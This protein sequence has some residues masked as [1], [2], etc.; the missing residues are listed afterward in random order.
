MKWLKFFIKRKA[1]KD[2]QQ[3]VLFPS[4]SHA[5]SKVL[6]I[7]VYQ[8]L[9][10][11]EPDRRR[12]LQRAAKVVGLT[13][14]AMGREIAQ[15]L[16]LP[17]ITSPD[18]S[19]IANLPARYSLA[20]FRRRGSIPLIEGGR[21]IGAACVD[22]ALLEGCLD[23]HPRPKFIL[24]TW[25]ALVQALVAVNDLKGKNEEVHELGLK[26]LQCILEEAL[27]YSARE[28]IISG[29]EGSL[30][31]R[32][33]VEGDL[34]A[35]GVVHAAATAPLQAL[36]RGNIG[37]G[38]RLPTLDAVEFS[39]QIDRGN[40]FTLKISSGASNVISL[41]TSIPAPEPVEAETIA[42]VD[43]D[44]SLLL[45]LKRFLEKEGFRVV[46][47]TSPLDVL[48]ALVSKRERPIVLLSDMHMPQMKGDELLKRI[49]EDA[50]ICSTPVI[51]LTS[52][53][54]PATHIRVLRAGADAYVTKNSHP[55][56][57]LAHIGRVKERASL[58]GVG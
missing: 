14:E 51:L 18:P 19:S 50:S 41:P 54:D 39:V 13:E 28:I 1:T 12:L 5:L 25:D 20:E 26:A 23:P 35:E 56:I 53:E 45:V 48:D 43:D 4:A 29:E 52:D 44:P 32:F 11:N 15:L 46:S 27:T 22:P 10:R 16:G 36:L 30:Q 49:R 34:M 58:L 42:I 38:L 7:P 3:G 8:D 57:I 17:F 37:D 33:P 24:S 9:L 40:G 21:V 47:Y 55:S 2:H 31:Y 6:P